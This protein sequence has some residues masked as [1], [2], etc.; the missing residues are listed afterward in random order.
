[1]RRVVGWGGGGTADS[2]S[3]QFTVKTGSTVVPDDATS[4]IIKQK[5]GLAERNGDVV[6]GRRLIKKVSS[7]N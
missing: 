5:P 4:L 7:N 3:T 2:F 1:M 6:F